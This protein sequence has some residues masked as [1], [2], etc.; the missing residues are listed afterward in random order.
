[1]NKFIPNSFQMPN[2][3][4]D[5]FLAHL[6][7]NAFKCYALISR[8]TTGWQKQSDRISVSQFMMKCGIKNRKTA[9]KCLEELEGINLI[10]TFKKCGEITEFSLNFNPEVPECE[11]VPKNGTSTN[12][13]AEPVPKNGTS[14]STKNWDTTKHNIKN[15]IT[16]TSSS[17]KISDVCVGKKSRFKFSDDD[18]TA[19]QWIFGLVKKLNPSVKAPSFDSWANEIRLM[20]ERDGRTHREICE[21]FQ[22]ANQD[23]FWKANIL[24]PAKLREKWDQLTVKKNNAKPQRKTVSELNAIE[25]N[26]EEGWRGM[27]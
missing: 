13:S 7:G 23:S 4:V 8:Q 22:W 12:F 15:N 26:T 18:M 6:S 1:M 19:G 24:S 10:F 14:T 11:P 27:L 17:E 5:D 2:A 9:M 20:R 25:W 21:L 3:I 16:N